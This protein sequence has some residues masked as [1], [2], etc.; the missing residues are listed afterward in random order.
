MRI[1]ILG[2]ET[3]AAGTVAAWARALGAEARVVAT[4][5]ELAGCDVLHV[6]GSPAPDE[7]AL[8]LAAAARR[9]GARVSVELPGWRELRAVGPV[10]FRELL[11]ALAPDLL[12]ATPAEWQILGGAYLSAPL[13]VLRRRGGC[14][15]FSAEARLELAGPDVPIADES[16]CAAAFV[17]GFL[18][19]GSLEEAGR[20]ALD[21]AAGCAAETGPA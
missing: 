20:R 9:A 10:A 19:G 17:A 3:G 13:A 7:R 16:D 8:A 11:D 18:L 14:T 21:A 15:V 2:D 6:P 5:D 4:A 12:L 1:A